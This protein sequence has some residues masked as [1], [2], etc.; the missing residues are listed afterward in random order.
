MIAS[1]KMLMSFFCVSSA[2]LMFGGVGTAIEFYHFGEAN[3]DECLSKTDDGFS[4]PISLSY[5]FPFF[6]SKHT[7]VIVSLILECML[8]D[9]SCILL[10][11]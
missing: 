10:V 1:R 6:N 3:N 11:A 5:P 9:D 2:L 4:S 7:E 8:L